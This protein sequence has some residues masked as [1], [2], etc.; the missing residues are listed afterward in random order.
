MGGP[1]AIKPGISATSFIK[2][3]RI[4]RKGSNK[5]VVTLV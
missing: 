1:V 5:A 3:D 2:E 4:S